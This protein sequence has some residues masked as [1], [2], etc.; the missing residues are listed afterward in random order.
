MQISQRFPKADFF[1]VTKLVSDIAN[2]HKDCCRGD[3]LE[4]MR[5][6]VKHLIFMYVQRN[7]MPFFFSQKIFSDFFSSCVVQF[8][9][10]L[11]S[12]V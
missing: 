1:T 12:S 6:R 8:A 2:M 4:C 3:M 11:N 5:D 7:Y 10:E 9:L